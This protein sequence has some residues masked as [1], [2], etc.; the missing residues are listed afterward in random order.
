MVSVSEE[1][2]SGAEEALTL[3]IGSE[4]IESEAESFAVES[5]DA[6]ES[7]FEG[8]TIAL[9]ATRAV[10][11][12]GSVPEDSEGAATA[13]ESVEAKSVPAENVAARIR[14]RNLESV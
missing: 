5:V 7:T 11:E 2:A 12:I 6:I 4:T 10:S 1:S 13:V 14:V 9:S 3:E 8:S